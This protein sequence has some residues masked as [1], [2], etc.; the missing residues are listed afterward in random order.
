MAT[1]FIT[2]FGLQV[3]GFQLGVAHRHQLLVLPRR[4]PAHRCVRSLTSAVPLKKQSR[5]NDCA[6]FYEGLVCRSF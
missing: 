2:G 1:G 6:Y 5:V 3:P 4:H